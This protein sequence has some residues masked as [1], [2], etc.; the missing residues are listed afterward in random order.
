[1]A[2]FK[3]G[4]RVKVVAVNPMFMQPD[5]PPLVGREGVIVSCEG[6]VVWDYIVHL[7][8]AIHK[9]SDLPNDHWGFHTSNLAPLTD[10]EST[11]TA[12]AHEKV[13]EVLKPTY[14]EP[15]VE[16]QRE[17]IGSPDWP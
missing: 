10:G 14:T 12:W 5:Y 1:M 8:G 13:R 3:V 7:P 9:P 15:K 4:Q 2:T 17:H 16:P 6:G 11:D